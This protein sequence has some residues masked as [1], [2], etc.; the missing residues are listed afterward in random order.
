VNTKAAM[1]ILFRLFLVFG[2]AVPAFRPSTAMAQHSK[3][4]YSA[5]DLF[6]QEAEAIDT[7]GIRRYSQD[8]V[9][10]ILNDQTGTNSDPQFADQ[11][12]DR[13]DKAEQA[14]RAGKGKL[15]PETAVVKA[16]NDLMQKMGAPQT[17]MAKVEDLHKFRARLATASTFPALFTATRNGSDCYPGEAIFLLYFLIDHNGRLSEH[18]ADDIAASQ[19]FAEM[20]AKP[21]GASRVQGQMVGGVVQWPQGAEAVISTFRSRHGRR[22]TTTLFKNMAKTFGI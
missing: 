10:L 3:P 15:V 12:A 2:I 13:L 5:P 19:Q 11:L 8:L 16:F 17:Y 9:A 22:S 6:N 18:V 14:A 20:A 7:A 1:A 4:S 21:G